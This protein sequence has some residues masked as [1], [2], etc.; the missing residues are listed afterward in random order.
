MVSIG[1]N[2]EFIGI[3]EGY[4]LKFGNFKEFQGVDKFPKNLYPQQGVYGFLLEKPIID[5]IYIVYTVM[6]PII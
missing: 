1:F 4:H 3:P 5:N 6:D 2:A